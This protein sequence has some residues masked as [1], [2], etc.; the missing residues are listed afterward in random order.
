MIYSTARYAGIVHEGRKPGTW[1]YVPAIRQWILDKSNYHL[2][3]LLEEYGMARLVY[4]I[5]RKIMEEGI[6]PFK[7]FE[8]A[9]ERKHDEIFAIASKY[10][11]KY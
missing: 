9:L 4:L 2:F 10:G 7:F 6:P 11:F 5:G 1:P 3:D 8:L